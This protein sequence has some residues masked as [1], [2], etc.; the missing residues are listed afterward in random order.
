M[1]QTYLRSKLLCPHEADSRAFEIP[2][3]GKIPHEMYVFCLAM[4]AD[5]LNAGTI[6]ENEK[7]EELKRVVVDVLSKRIGQYSTS[8]EED[9]KILEDKVVNMRR[10]MA[11]EVR[12]GEKKILKKAKERVEAWII[13]PPAKRLKA[14]Y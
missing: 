2:V 5:A 10:R 6:P 13:P 8:I 14:N 12:L 1:M 9:E 7:T 11:V 3:S 4:M